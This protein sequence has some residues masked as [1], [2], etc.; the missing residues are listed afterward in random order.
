MILYPDI[1]AA[2][3]QYLTPLLKDAHVG[4]VKL[5]EPG[6]QVIVRDDDGEPIEES[7]LANLRFGINC[8]APTLTEVEI[9]AAKV[10]GLLN[11]W[12][13]HLIL[14]CNATTG[15]PVK[16]EAGPQRYLT[17][18]ALALGSNF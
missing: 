3:T 7:M 6:C 11:D 17:G 13:D 12:S 14:M 4:A 5:D 15:R 16:G 10:S 8:Y 9:L 2:V 18:E 1:E